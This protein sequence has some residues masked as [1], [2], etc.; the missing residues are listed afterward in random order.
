MING[1]EK[2]IRSVMADL[3]S[4]GREISPEQAEKLISGSGIV[5]DGREITLLRDGQ[6]RYRDSTTEKYEKYREKSASILAR[7]G[8]M[9]SGL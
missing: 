1:N 2:K 7:V 6:L 5:I 3:R 4:T 9:R 8:K